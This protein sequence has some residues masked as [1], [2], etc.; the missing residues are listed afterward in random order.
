MW[1]AADNKLPPYIR[2]RSDVFSLTSQTIKSDNGSAHENKPHTVIFCAHFSMKG[3]VQIP[4]SIICVSSALGS[5]FILSWA[6]KCTHSAQLSIIERR[7]V[8]AWLHA[9]ADNDK[10]WSTSFKAPWST[11]V[12]RVNSSILSQTHFL[13]CFLT[14]TRLITCMYFVH[15]I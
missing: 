3:Q 1:S 15:V 10:Y 7:R 4:R 12:N 11:R 9:I 8:H 13:M 2:R 6:S 5:V 14:M